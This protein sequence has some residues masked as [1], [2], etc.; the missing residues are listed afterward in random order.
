[1]FIPAQVAREFAKN[2]GEKIQNLFHEITLKQNLNVKR[3]E[4]RILEPFP[5][6]SELIK[7][8][9]ELASK[10]NEYRKVVGEIL[11][12][13]RLWRWNDPVS[14]LYLSTRQ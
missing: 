11:N 14:N 2:R 8:E 5:E 4:Y 6:Y 7:I 3:S 1:M 13:I 12:H 9:E 10:L